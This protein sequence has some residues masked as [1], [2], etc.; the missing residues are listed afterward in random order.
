MGGNRT[1]EDLKILH[2]SISFNKILVTK[3]LA[4]LAYEYIILFEK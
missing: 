2:F 3:I 4:K 1:K